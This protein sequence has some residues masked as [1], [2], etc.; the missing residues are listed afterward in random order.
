[1]EDSVLDQMAGELRRALQNRGMDPNTPPDDSS[2]PPTAA[3]NEY[4]RRGGDR[5][6]SADGFVKALIRRVTELR[7]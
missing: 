2:P 3:F 4:Q 5:Y 7:P 1:M 6:V